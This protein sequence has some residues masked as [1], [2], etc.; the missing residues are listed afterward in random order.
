MPIDCRKLA[1]A[2]GA[3]ILGVDIAA[4]VDAWAFG[5]IERLFNE[6]TIVVFRGQHLSLQQHIAFSRRFGE[7][8]VNVMNEYALA[9]HPEVLVISNVVENGRCIGLADAG[10]NWHTDMSYMPRPPRCSLLYAMKVPEQDGQPLGDTLFVSTA[11]A[12]DTLAAAMKDRLAGLKAIHRSSARIRNAENRSQQ[13]KKSGDELPDVIH[14][15]VRT[16]P[17]TGRKSI[18]VR[19]GECI[20]IVGMPGEEALPLLKMLS[21]FCVQPEFMYRHRWRVGDLLMWDNCTAQHVAVNDYKLPQ[22]RLMYRT[23]VNGTV[24]F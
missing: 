17:V 20:G 11:A 16:H 1:P 24:P 21:D 22:E 18:Y 13:A 6:N 5:E 7:L 12:Y 2:L 19:E 23:T 3:E 8:E 14:P 15:V 10:R 4:G 9:V